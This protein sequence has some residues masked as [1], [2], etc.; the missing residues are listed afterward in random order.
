MQF[1]SS[2]VKSFGWYEDDEQVYISMEYL[3]HGDLSHYL[4]K[5]G[6]LPQHEVQCIAH[7]ILDGL[8]T[9]HEHDFVHRDLKPQNVLIKD[10]G[11]DWWVKLGDFGVSKRMVDAA[12]LRTVTGTRDFMAPE[13]LVK[14]RFVICEALAGRDFYTSAVD[15]W[16]LGAL[17]FQALTGSKPFESLASCVDSTIPFPYHIL[18]AQH[19]S[20]DGCDLIG[21][22]LQVMPEKRPTASEALD[23]PWLIG[24]RAPP[25]RES[26]ESLR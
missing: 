4:D 7:Q 18:Q 10:C 13:V 25:L 14:G 17:V 16:A 20:Q 24:Q 19:I 9:M 12:S 21:R 1:N 6:P 23:D 22:L 5:F 2:F 3:P 26:I 11:P 8:A 15:M